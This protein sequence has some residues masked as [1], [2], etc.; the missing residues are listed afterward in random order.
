LTWIADG[1]L[2]HTVYIGLRDYKPAVHVRREDAGVNK[3]QRGSSGSKCNRQVTKAAALLAQ[4]VARAEAI[5]ANPD[6]AHVVTELRL[7]PACALCWC[8][9]TNGAAAITETISTIPCSYDRRC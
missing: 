1:L 5:N 2:R 8:F 3:A 7:Y 6:L 4:L 9:S